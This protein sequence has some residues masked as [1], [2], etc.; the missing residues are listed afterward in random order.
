MCRVENME[1]LRCVSTSP[2]PSTHSS[3]PSHPHSSSSQ[4]TNRA[5]YEEFSIVHNI[6]RHSED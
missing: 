4:Y 6:Q 2:P 5:K 3:H 1:L